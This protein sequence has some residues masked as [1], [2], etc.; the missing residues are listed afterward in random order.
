MQGTGKSTLAAMMV[1]ALESRGGSCAVVDSDTMATTYRHDSEQAVLAHSDVAHL[2][3]EHLPHKFDGGKPGDKVIRID[4]V[5][6]L[7][8]QSQAV[9]QGA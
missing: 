8:T 7:A 5:P 3:L 1:N 2:F 6:E 9:T 4:Y